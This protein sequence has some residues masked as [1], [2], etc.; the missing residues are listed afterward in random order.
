MKKALA[1]TM[2]FVLTM[3]SV[4]PG[5]SPASLPMASACAPPPTEPT[6]IPTGAAPQTG[7]PTPHE[8]PSPDDLSPEVEEAR[9]RQAIEAVL[10]K[11]LRYW[12][13]R[14]QA[15]VSHVSVEGEWAH[16]VAEW[17]SEERTL[18]EG[19]NLIAKRSLDGAWQALMP[20]AE[21]LYLQWLEAMPGSLV[22]AGEKGVARAQ[23]A[24]ADALRRPRA[25]ATP[26]APA[27]EP[28][29]GPGEPVLQSPTP[30]PQHVTPDLTGVLTIL[31]DGQFVYGPNVAGF[32]LAAYLNQNSSTLAYLAQ[33][34]DDKASYYSINPRVLLTILEIRSGAVTTRISL[35]QD[36]LDRIVGYQ[37]IVGY[38]AQLFELGQTLM[39]AYYD[40][41]Y[42]ETPGQDLVIPLTLQDGETVS[43]SS[44]TNAATLAILT[45]LAPVSSQRQ[46]QTL[47]SIHDPGGFFHT[48]RRLFPDSDPLDSSNKVIT[49]DAPPSALLKLPFA[50]GDT[51]N[52][53]GGPH[54]NDGSCSGGDPYSAVDFAPGVGYCVIPG[55]RW[56]VSPAAGT[57]TQVNCGGCQI[58][59]SHQDGWG[60]YYYHV[61]NP[62]VS[63]GQGV[64]QDQ[65]IGNPSTM[66]VCGGDCGGCDGNATGTHVHYALTYNG[67]FVVIEGT[68]FEGWVVHGTTTCYG[69]YLEKNGQQIWVGSP[70]TSQCSSPPPPPPTCDAT[71]LP[72]GYVK[73][74]DENG[75]C[76]FN[77]TQNV[78]YGADS[79]YK[80]KTFTNGVNCN[81]DVFGDPLPGVAKACYVPSSAP[82]PPP[83]PSGNWHVEYFNDTHLGSRCYETWENSTYIFKD[84]EYGAPASGCNS[85][86]FSARFTRNVDFAGGTYSFHLSHDDGA[87]LYV[88]GQLVVDAWWDG[89]GEHD[90]GKALSAGEHQVKIEYYDHNDHARIEAFWFGPGALPNNTRD[91]NQ[92]WASYWGNRWFWNLPALRQNEGSGFIEHE[93]GNDGPGYG[94]PNDNFTSRFERTVNFACGRWQFDVHTDD[95]VRLWVDGNLILDEWRSQVADFSREVDLSA[96]NHELK[97]EHGDNGGGA[98]IHLSWDKVADCAPSTPT[99]QDPAN[100]TVLNEGQDITLSWTGNTQQYYAEFWGGP[101][102]TLNSGWQSGTSWHIGSQW[103]GYTYSWRVKGRNGTTESGWSDTWTFTVRPAAPSNLSAQ[104][105]SCSAVNLYWSDNSGNE[106]GYKIYRNGSYVGQVGMNT[107][108]YQDTGLS[109]NTGYSYYVK[110]FRGSIESA[111]S[112]TVNITTPPCAPPQP[113]LRPYAPSGYPY[114]VVPSSIQGTHAVNTL[115]AGKPT[116]FDWHFINSGNE[117]ASGN[118]HVEL[119][120]G[121]T[122][123][124]RYPYSN[125]G[126]GW[127]GGFDDWNETIAT[128]GWHTVRLITD[129]D[130]TIAESN[131]GNNVFEWEFYWTPTAPY[132][133]DMESGTND[134]NAT[135]LWHQV[136]ASSPYPES[137]SGA[138]SWWYGQDATGDYDTGAANSGDLTSP[139]VYVPSTGYYLRFWYRYETETQGQDLDQ[140]RVQV[141]VDGGPFENILPLSDDPMNWWLQSPVIDLSGYAGHTIQVRFHFNTMDEQLN[142]Y[143]GWY[144][145]DF[146]ISDTPPPSCSDSHEPNNNPAE[147]IPIAYGQS[148]DADICPGGDYDFYQF[149]GAQGDPVVVDIDAMSE[150]SWLD[151]YV[152]LIADDGSTVLAEH[153]DEIVGE[154]R[155]SLLGYNL[156]YT[157]TYYLKVKAW[158]HPSVGGSDYFYT[159]H[160]FT[161]DANP[162][163]A[164]ITSP[165]TDS[166]LDPVTVTVTV[167]TTDEESGVNRVEFLWHDADWEN[168]DWVWLGADQ[169]GRDG[170]SWDFD[171]SSLAEQ[172]GGAF[173]I[174]AFDWVGHWTGAGAWNLG[175]DRTPPTVAASVSQMYGDAPF[176]DFWVNWWDSYDALSGIAAYDVQ[177][178]EGAGGTWMDLAISTTETYTRFVGLDGHTYYFRARAR[179][180]AGN[181]S[182]YAGGDGDAQ[183][184]VDICDT[185][186]D[187]YEADN[188]AGSANWIT[189]DGVFQTHNV[190][191][192]GDQDWVKFYAAAGVTY[193]LA[194]TNT[195]G[196]ADTVLYLYGTDG[197]TLI[198]S[199]DDYAG[200]WS[201]RLDWQPSASGVY[202]GKVDHWDPWAYGCTT[203]YG[204]VILTND[205]TPPTGSVSINAGAT[206]AAS[207]AVTLNLAG[208]DVGTGVGQV[209]ASNSS[210]FG[211]ATW[212]AYATSL[213]WTLTAGEG[214]KTVYIRFRDRAGNESDAC[215]DTIV[216]DTTPPTGNILIEGGAEVVTDTQV[217]LTL[218]ASDTNGVTHLRLRNDAAAWS[219]WNPFVTS[220]TWTLP[221][222]P[223][224]HTVGVQF[225]DGAGNV[226]VAYSDAI[227]YE[228]PVY[229]V[230]LPLLMRNRR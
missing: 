181:Q 192:E 47:T 227:L 24:E 158:N 143:R 60:S 65:H 156:S 210:D 97:L 101:A 105:A 185:A 204:L 189:T 202:Y 61:A 15:A 205:E 149:S 32:D 201:S 73:C 68:A 76:S 225:R 216:L 29:E 1:I 52:F 78:Y 217:V 93:W 195:G 182:T 35:T 130:N 133:D 171:T 113:D 226:S 62:Q 215:S 230:Y 34:L 55:D 22:P 99:L 188:A 72:A 206:Y 136:D 5:A 41:L 119:W 82:P 123:Y 128:P 166:L 115:Y 164:E 154:V 91:P 125:Y 116:Y 14:Y 39:E 84:W 23:A 75:Y 167:S 152:Y 87:R 124:V 214:T 135:S 95:G 184:T 19:I 209:M 190:H 67:A 170:W 48:Y 178:R 117:T 43:V 21:G 36:R 155:D 122:R 30:Q 147:A 106:E 127:S 163:S 191:T 17:Q 169:D 28:A 131:E 211:G 81:N 40:R 197:S 224:E 140:R 27:K 83:P 228:P 114:P 86:D 7:T 104:T 9:A 212:V 162:S 108:S 20:S 85:N 150:G 193:T 69:G 151:P 134:W 59:I 157:G 100:A 92:W 139:P 200:M 102:G 121:D 4:V 199:N 49:P 10:D 153:D 175:L 221:A 57:V 174:W 53:S 161:D 74:A 165:T 71:G 132:A 25:T 109:E 196:H 220:H 173:Y 176:R 66:P 98:A 80:V 103:A 207:T 110:A 141:S 142:H 180:F 96:G 42:A 11:Y 107:T 159:L 46:W 208:A 70:V 37:D 137:H 31:S 145:D 187:A 194:T 222:Q 18:Q 198:D 177:Y 183:H 79:C 58:R 63:S 89:D 111:A 54:D 186:P 2:S 38:D 8:P 45:A 51:W 90:G 144:V 26:T 160:L 120:V 138:H 112:N 118:F 148:L 172:R 179:D 33:D 56:I 77:G 219:A 88:D 229:S 50:C 6:P 218:S 94:L 146:E 168:S 16:G 213:N 203:E 223:G 3:I 126:A 44:N 129:P 64:S 13:P 12:G